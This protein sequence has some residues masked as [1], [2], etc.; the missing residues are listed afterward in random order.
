MSRRQDLQDSLAPVLFLRLSKASFTGFTCVSS[1]YDKKI[2]L[3]WLSH[4]SFEIVIVDV[5][6]NHLGNLVYE[7]RRQ[8]QLG[9]LGI[10]K[11]VCSV[12]T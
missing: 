8:I 3:Y 2:R 7:C 10:E 1:S 4:S 9:F 5:R 6:S 12:L 11:F